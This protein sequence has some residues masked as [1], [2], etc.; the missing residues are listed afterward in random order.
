MTFS[1]QQREELRIMSTF[2]DGSHD[3]NDRLCVFSFR[4][5]AAAI[6]ML[7]ALDEAD[8]INAAGARLERRVGTLAAYIRSIAGHPKTRDER[9]KEAVQ[10]LDAQGLNSLARDVG[11]PGQQGGP[12]GPCDAG[13]A[14]LPACGDVLPSRGPSDWDRV[15]E[16]PKGHANSHR[17]G[18]RRWE[19]DLPDHHVGFG[20]SAAIEAMRR[21]RREVG[22]NPHI[23]QD[24]VAHLKKLGER[25]R[26]WSIEHK[27]WWRPDSMGYTTDIAGAGLY[28][29]EEA[30]EIVKGSSGKDE[31]AIRQ[32]SAVP[33]CVDELISAAIHLD[34]KAALIGLIDAIVDHYDGEKQ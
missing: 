4:I 19:L 27:A 2:C 23:G 10:Y 13:L 3:H 22:A 5:R 7:D 14:G 8:Q 32:S 17:G 18:G 28:S 15:C 12:L 11:E 24:A 20:S 16:L 33:K 1:R 6:P 9:I 21:P 31:V 25:V 34:K 30:A 26:I 29:P